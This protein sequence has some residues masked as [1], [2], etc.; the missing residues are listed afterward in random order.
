MLNIPGSNQTLPNKPPG[1][2]QTL[3]NK[4]LASKDTEDTRTAADL[5]RDIAQ[6]AIRLKLVSSREVPNDPPNMNDASS[7]VSMISDISP[8]NRSN[9]YKKQGLETSNLSDA[10]RG[11]IQHRATLGANSR[12]MPKSPTEHCATLGAKPLPHSPSLNVPAYN[13]HSPT[14]GR[15]LSRM[16]TQGD[17]SSR[18]NFQVSQRISSRRNCRDYIE[19]S[20][21]KFFEFV[22]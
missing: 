18:S 22:S 12:A 4:P 8:S 21:V 7:V 11:F 19:K 17:S 20:M 2:N 1:S 3:P 14:T 13:F 16:P 9:Q 15:R 5:Y 6:Y 10:S